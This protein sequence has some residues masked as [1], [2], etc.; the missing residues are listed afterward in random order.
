MTIHFH[1]LP[2]GWPDTYQQPTDH[3]GSWRIYTTCTDGSPRSCTTRADLQQLEKIDLLSARSTF[4][5]FSLKAQTGQPLS[6]LFNETQ[7]HE[8]HEFKLHKHD[9]Q[10]TK[11]WRIWK[12]GKVRTYFVYLP[13]KR[14]VILKTAAKRVDKL[15]AG[16]KLEL[17]TAARAVFSTIVSNNFEAQEI[18]G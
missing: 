16:E 18:H 6:E 14:L 9:Q 7:C 1:R 12:A 15:S 8:A 17:E 11:I 2:Y 3:D 5:S 10:P 13:N 4:V